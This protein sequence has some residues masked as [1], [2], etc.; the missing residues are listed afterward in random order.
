VTAES[1]DARIPSL[2]LRQLVLRFLRFGGLAW[3]GPIAQIA[4]LRREMVDDEKWIS[5]ERFNR[6]LAVYQ[7]LPGPE[8]QELCIYFGTLAR[9]RLGGLLAGL[10]FL[11][12]GFL[13][14]L[15]LAWWYTDIG[16]NTPVFAAA[17]A[18]AQAAVVALIVRGLQRIGS[19]ALTDG[20]L[21]AIAIAAF[22]ASAAGLL[23]A[24]PLVVGAVAYPL[25][26]RGHRLVALALIGPLLIGSVAL[27]LTA[28]PAE[29]D[30]PV[31]APER[32]PSNGELLVSGIR[33][34]ALS[35]GGAYTAIPF[36]EADAVGEDGWMTTGQFLDGL[37]LS[38]VIPAP[39]VIFATFVGYAGGGPL[40]A[41]AMTIGIFLPAFAITL[42]G[43][44][45]LEA[46]VAN[47]RLHAILDGITA[48]VV[49]LV[50]ATLLQLAPTA[51]GTLP[52]LVIFGLALAALYLWRSSAAVAVVIAGAAAAGVLT[53]GA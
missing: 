44:R 19:R 33:A 28:G 39:L 7:V 21:A 25:A 43:H 16:M 12:P 53:L 22:V 9:G 3:G 29:V 1:A 20:M 46:A 31:D 47:V 37:A 32:T 15:A 26:R 48:A 40:G 42:T 23:F 41:V 38:G 51:V 10:S 4:M 49:G 13:L 34:G 27:A 18:G 17:F 11:L 24:V 8:A 36:V 6:T 30:G 50:A 14:M 5:S 2:G 45:Y 52:A 35:F